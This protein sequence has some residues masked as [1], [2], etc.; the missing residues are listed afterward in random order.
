MSADLELTPST[1]A[2][3][4]IDL[5]RG[6]TQGTTQPHAASHADVVEHAALLAHACRNAGGRVILVHAD[7]GPSGILLPHALDES[8]ACR[9]GR[10]GPVTNST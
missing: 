5:Q 8:G 3:V 7:A 1:T 6:I 4:L 9:V 2:L 10:G